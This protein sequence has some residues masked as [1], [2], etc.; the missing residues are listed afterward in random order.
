MS[1]S[2][3]EKLQ[4]DILSEGDVGDEVKIFPEE[5]YNSDNANDIKL[6]K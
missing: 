6:K 2:E 5:L 3:E 1:S 4:D